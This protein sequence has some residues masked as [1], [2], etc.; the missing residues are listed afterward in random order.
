MKHV[1]IGIIG[2]GRAAQLHLQA[3]YHVGGCRI[4]I[5]SIMALR[6]SQLREICNQYPAIEQ[7]TLSFDEVIYD[8]E[9]DVVDIC[10]PPYTHL[11]MCTAALKAGKHVICEKPLSGYFGDPDDPRPIGHAVSKEHMYQKLVEELEKFSE[12]VRNSGKQF[13]YAENFIYA[14]AIQKAAEIITA[15]QSRILFMKGEES[16]RGST[17]P[18]AGE[19]D[20]TGGG[21]LIRTGIHPLSAILWLKQIEA[22]AHKRE[23]WV[24]SVLC[25]T[26][27]VIST[28]SQ[29]DRRHINATPHDVE[30]TAALFLTFSDETKAV[31]LATDTLLGGSRNYVEAYCNDT[32]LQCNLTMHNAMQ[33]YLPDDTHMQNVELSEMTTIKTG[34]NNPFVAD[35]VL[36]GYVAEMQEFLMCVCENRPPLCDIKLSCDIIRTLYSGYVS[37]Q[38][39]CRISIRK[40]D[41]KCGH[42]N[43]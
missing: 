3:L 21:T 29:S 12:T 42:S 32:V 43:D 40:E 4:R 9:I 24:E 27:N 38:E 18:V 20:K 33:C 7:Y 19:W 2:A 16:L 8:K 23:I 31:V 11:K 22:R 1:T 34:W 14:P 36:R 30:D 5:K 28:L 35:E 37:A 17:S 41:E 25:D 15:R 10:T 39:G 6:E 26:G 13:M